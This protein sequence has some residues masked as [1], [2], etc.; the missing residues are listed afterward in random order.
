MKKLQAGPKKQL[1]Y[2]GL[3]VFCLVQTQSIF[4]HRKK[5]YG[6]CF[7]PHARPQMP[8]NVYNC[9]E[10]TVKPNLYDRQQHLGSAINCHLTFLS[11][12]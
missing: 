5:M 8:L 1:C 12:T 7:S 9:I 6:W 2:K 4:F 10:D 11:F 3:Y